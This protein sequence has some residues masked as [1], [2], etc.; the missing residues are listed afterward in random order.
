M[1][2]VKG[3][4]CTSEN[5]KTLYLDQSISS[6]IE[7]GGS[8]SLNEPPCP[9]LLRRTTRINLEHSVKQTNVSGRKAFYE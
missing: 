7:A 5:W 8:R 1:Q 2:G 3:V 4:R 9:L 6:A